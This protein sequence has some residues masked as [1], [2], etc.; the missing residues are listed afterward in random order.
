MARA[1]AGRPRVEED[2]TEAAPAVTVA[3]R[4]RADVGKGGK[5]H[6]TADA[7]RRG[8]EAKAQRGLF[9][10]YIR[11]LQGP[12]VERSQQRIREIDET[13][14]CG[15]RLKKAPVFE[16]GKRV[17]TTARPLPLL[18]SEQALL[19]VERRKL[20]AGLARRAPEDL[21]AAF[22]AML[23]DYAARHELTRDILEAVGVPA[24]D[25]DQV[26]LTES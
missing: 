26:G 5:G 2:G 8:S 9:N 21:R 1:R 15:T 3:G 19:M 13:L 24:A 22:L 25:L 17:G 4:R 6:I 18:P 16:G 20:E 10:R 7:R 11:A 12:A 14:A 23:P